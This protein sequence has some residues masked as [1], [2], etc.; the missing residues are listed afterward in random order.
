MV[1]GTDTT[2]NGYSSAKWAA[3]GYSPTSYAHLEVDNTS[4][5]NTVTP[6]IVVSAPL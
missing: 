6:T 5:C 3:A 4:N 1:I 2:R